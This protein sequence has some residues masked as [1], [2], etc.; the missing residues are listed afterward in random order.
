MP[1][2]AVPWCVLG[3][4]LLLACMHACSSELRPSLAPWQVCDVG[5]DR[6]EAEVA[7][8]QLGLSSGFVAKAVPGAYFGQGS[9]SVLVQM[10]CT[11]EEALLTDCTYTAAPNCTHAQ[12]AGVIC[13]PIT[14]ACVVLPTRGCAGRAP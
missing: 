2:P 14:G 6:R 10:Q 12:D 8:K 1:F 9:R 4:Q 11:G 7:C 5:F 13:L 3:R